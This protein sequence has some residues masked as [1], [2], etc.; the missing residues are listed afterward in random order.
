MRYLIG[1]GT[2]LGLDDSIGL[3]IAESIGEDGLAHDFQAIDL[4]GNLLDLLHYFVPETEAVLIIDT[5]RM[6]AEPGEYRFFRPEQVTSRKQL[7]GFSTHEDDLMKVLEFADSLALSLPPITIM[8]IEPARIAP[9]E[10]LS[11][12]LA[13]RFDEY[14]EAAVGFFR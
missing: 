5:A 6:G 9:E 2:Y 12:S 8:G 10:G 1:I 14:V 11:A 7:A 13:A 3:R 4:G